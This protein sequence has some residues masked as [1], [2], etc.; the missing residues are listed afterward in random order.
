MTIDAHQH[1]WTLTRGDYGWLTPDLTVLY[2]D[3]VPADLWPQ[4]QA[5]GVSGT[6]AVQAADTEAETEFLLA[7]ADEHDWILGVVGWVDL[8][9]P[10]AV[11]SIARLAEHPRL[12]GLR[13]MIQDLEDDTWMLRPALR[14][15][16][17]AMVAHDLTFD[18]LVLPRHLGHLRQFLA[19]YPDLRVVV[20]HCAKPEIAKGLFDDWARDLAAVAEAPNTFCKLSGLVTEAGPDW[21]PDT[22][23]PYV[24]HVLN[25]FGPDRLLFGSDWP[26]LTL[27]GDYAGWM[28]VVQD[29]IV[30]RV[31]A[32]QAR[33]IMG[34]TARRAYPRMAR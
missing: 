25:V 1:F 18:A 17:E 29:R 11:T 30:S 31:S 20:D 6:I 8:E 26:V 33:A 9:A 7:L 13:P 4:M 5:A 10:T 27:A 28:Q 21:Q 32:D 34:Q 2:R 22:L 16:I 24:E 23:M 3:F 12:V 15:G 14:A 19:L